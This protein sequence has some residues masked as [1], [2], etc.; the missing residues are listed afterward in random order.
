VQGGYIFT[1][2]HV[3][4]TVELA[5]AAYV[6]FNFEEDAFGQAKTRHTYSFDEATFITDKALDYTR[7]KVLEN[8]NKPLSDWG[9]LELAPDAR[10]LVGDPVNI[11]QH[12]NGDSKQIALTSNDVLSI[13]GPRL[14]YRADTEPG[15]SGS[16]VFNQD[17]KV[18]ALHHA[19]KLMA[20]GGL[21]INEQGER[22]S[23]NRGILLSFIL[24]QIAK[25]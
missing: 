3:I 25:R 15:S 17:W 9:F 24:E 13:W 21:Q 14:F 18:I 22:A 19:G 11:I 7:L 1:N 20:E 10:P 2:N 16:P 6:E 4:P 12:P 5:A 23:A 8:N